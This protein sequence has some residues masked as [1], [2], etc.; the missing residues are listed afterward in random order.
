M[1]RWSSLLSLLC[2]LALLAVMAPAGAEAAPGSAALP[3][4]L[5]QQPLDNSQ[6]WARA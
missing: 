1:K 6:D 2:L 4:P 5:Q 3:Q